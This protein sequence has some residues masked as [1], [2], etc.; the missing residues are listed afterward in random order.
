MT[1]TDAASTATQTLYGILDRNDGS[2]RIPSTF[3]TLNSVDSLQK[4]GYVFAGVTVD[5]QTVT[6]VSNCLVNYPGQNL[7]TTTSTNCPTGWGEG[8]STSTTPASVQLGW[9]FDLPGT[10][11]RMVANQVQVFGGVADF[12]TLTPSAVACTGGVTGLEYAL[13][14][15]TGG[16]TSFSVFDLNGTGIFNS[17]QMYTNPTSGLSYV[18]S[19]VAITGSTI[20]APTNFSL[21]PVGTVVGSNSGSGITSCVGGSCTGSVVVPPGLTT[22]AGC[23]VGYLPGWGCVGAIAPAYS[24]DSSCT[25]LS[26]IRQQ[27]SLPANRLYWRQMFTQ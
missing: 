6:V 21:P 8:S 23:A 26:C 2:T 4:Q 19:V 1:N 12:I 16:A 13:N 18:V 5:N 3:R 14:P 15:N 7:N 25:G 10:G 24:L 22:T 17:A 9:Y 11:E 20:T 27:R